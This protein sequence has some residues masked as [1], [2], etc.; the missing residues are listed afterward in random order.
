MHKSTPQSRCTGGSD[1]LGHDE[2]LAVRAG[3]ES[4]GLGVPDESLLLGIESEEAAEA[5]RAALEL[6]P[7]A[8]G[9]TTAIGSAR[10]RVSNTRS[11]RPPA[12]LNSVTSKIIFVGPDSG[13]AIGPPS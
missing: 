1:L 11:C 7:R 8:G 2:R 12:V 5:I 3:E 4:V 13:N 10:P 9:L 6:H